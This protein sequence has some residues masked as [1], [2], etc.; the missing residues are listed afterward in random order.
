MSVKKKVPK[1]KTTSKKVAATK[2]KQTPTRKTAKK[3]SK[4]KKKVLS[5][6]KNNKKKVTQSK[7][8]T[9]KAPSKKKV[10]KKD[11]S[12]AMKKGVKTVKKVVKKVASKKAPAKE[13]IIQKQPAKK[14]VATKAKKVSPPKEVEEKIVQPVA[15]N[16]KNILLEARKRTAT[17]SIFKMRARRNTP[18]LFTLEDVRDILETKKAT[19]KEEKQVFEQD[20]ANKKKQNTLT[21]QEAQ[22]IEKRVLGAASLADILGY[23]PNAKKKKPNHQE[24]EAQRVP[25]KFKKYYKA[26]IQLRAHVM[27]GLE[28][29]TQ[30]TLKRSSKEDAGD[31][32][33]YGQHMADAGTDNSDRDFALSLV[34]S[35]QEALFE[36]EEAIQRILNN[37]YGVCEITGK[38]IAKER[39]MAVPFTRYS[40]EGQQELE[41]TKKVNQRGH[42][43]SEVSVEEAARFGDEDFEN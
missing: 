40:L 21:E 23:N 22:A 32:S 36:I 8:S 27:A 5:T 30:E 24:D 33:G 14:R 25:E 12:P 41:R 13:K 43:F 2:K 39:L 42:A 31:L 17:P 26:L 28:V 1:K 9:K 19:E 7:Q 10:A 4:P 34:S 15:D 37:E 20:V 18:I 38:A 3:T 11:G 29:H 35:E 6:Q 16:T